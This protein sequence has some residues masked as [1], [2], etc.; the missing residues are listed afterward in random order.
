VLEIGLGTTNAD[1]MS[2]MGTVGGAK[3]GG[4]LRAFKEYL[5]NATI[6]GA[7]I[8]ESILF[9]EDR[10]KTYGVDQT[11]DASLERLGHNVGNE[12]DLI[13]DDGLH[14]PHANLRTL[15]FALPLLRPGGSVVIEDIWDRSLAIWQ[16]A[17]ELIPDEFEASVL[18][19]QG[20]YVFLARRKAS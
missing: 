14:A 19:A 8:D 1:V 3:P 17:A 11:D 9:T 2:H 10:I 20:A 18:E 13:I 16:V 7:D 5:P 12:F 6:F 4:S 15:Q